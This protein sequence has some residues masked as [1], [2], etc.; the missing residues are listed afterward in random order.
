MGSLDNVRDDDPG[1]NEV[2][3]EQIVEK[4]RA[5]KAARESRPCS[6]EQVD[7][8]LAILRDTRDYAKVTSLIS[9]ASQTLTAFLQ[10][11]NK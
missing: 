4:S 10:K 3:P 2:P 7:V 8:A 11:G 6:K 1:V 5:A 9:E